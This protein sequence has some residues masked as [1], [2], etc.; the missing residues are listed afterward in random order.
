M[1]NTTIPKLSILCI[2][3]FFSLQI[4]AQI[5]TNGITVRL[6]HKLLDFEKIDDEKLLTGKIGDFLNTEGL[7]YLNN[8]KFQALNSLSFTKIFTTLKTSDSI[9][10][11]RSGDEVSIPPF[12][13]TFN[14]R[15]LP[16]S[17]L[18]YHK[19]VGTLNSLYPLVIYAHPNYSCE[20][21]SVPND[22]LYSLQQSLSSDTFM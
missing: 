17:N 4:F 5:E 11:S 15:T 21:L 3:L 14:V 19:L 20:L 22:S 2:C 13:A 7:A 16:N 8:S 10:I 9:S 18:N 6:N 12:W 1:K